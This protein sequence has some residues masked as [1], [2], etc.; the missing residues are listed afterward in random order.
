MLQA[1]VKNPLVSRPDSIVFFFFSW[2]TLLGP[3]QKEENRLLALNAGAATT[4]QVGA[5]AVLL[6][7]HALLTQN[8][9]RLNEAFF[10]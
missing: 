10:L 6:T 3:C 2:K 7:G 8:K 1:F 4:S 5:R 9:W